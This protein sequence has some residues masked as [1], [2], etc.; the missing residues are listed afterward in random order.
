MYVD[1]YVQIFSDESVGCVY[2][3][4]HNIDTHMYVDIYV[5]TFAVVNVD[6]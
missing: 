6:F 5:Y 1:I 3:C 2:M 4:V